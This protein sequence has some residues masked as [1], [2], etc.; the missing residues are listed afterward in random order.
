MR[1]TNLY[2]S[3]NTKLK[4]L[5]CSNNQLTNLDISSY[6]TLIH[7]YCDGNQLES[8]NASGCTALTVFC[9]NNKLEA[10]AL[11]ALFGTLNSNAGTKEIHIG[12]NPGTDDCARSVA[13]LKGWTVNDFPW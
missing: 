10:A 11:N 3:N 1:L 4:G 2:V 13:E 5:N 6:T 12:G 7:L 9:T 8:L